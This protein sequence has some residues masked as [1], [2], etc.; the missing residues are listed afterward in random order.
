LK[1]T[2]YIILSRFFESTA[3]AKPDTTSSHILFSDKNKK[4][5][6]GYSLMKYPAEYM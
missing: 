3:T 1:K 6:A 5:T 4:E 2:G